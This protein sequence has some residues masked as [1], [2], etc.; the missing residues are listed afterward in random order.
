MLCLFTRLGFNVDL[1]VF[2][3]KY[4]LFFSIDARIYNANSYTFLSFHRSIVIQ[5][6][7]IHLFS[8]LCRTLKHPMT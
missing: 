4:F 3:E 7:V 2:D 5:P 1:Y 8:F 6:F